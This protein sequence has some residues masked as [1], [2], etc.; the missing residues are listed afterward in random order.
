MTALKIISCPSPSWS[1]KCLLLPVRS[2]LPA[3][4]PCCGCMQQDQVE[5]RSIAIIEQL[6]EARCTCF[7][8]REIIGLACPCQMAAPVPDSGRKMAQPH[9]PVSAGPQS[10]S[11]AFCQSQPPTRGLCSNAATLR[12]SICMKQTSTADHRKL[13]EASAILSLEMRHTSHR[14]LFTGFVWCQSLECWSHG[15]ACSLNSGPMALTAF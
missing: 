12:K 11:S 2:T 10:S 1:V 3:S 7:R 9:S 14:A 4:T 5:G 13:L 6:L 8:W 15:I